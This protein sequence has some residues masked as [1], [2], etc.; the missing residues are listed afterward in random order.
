MITANYTKGRFY[1]ED[2]RSV[3]PEGV[4][5]V[6]DCFKRHYLTDAAAAADTTR[7]EAPAVEAAP[8]SAADLARYRA[9][10][11][12]ICDEDLLASTV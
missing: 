10:D 7:P 5:H 3:R 6:M 11:A 12:V 8:L 9:L 4:A 1:D 2:R